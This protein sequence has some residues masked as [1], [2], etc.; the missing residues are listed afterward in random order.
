MQPTGCKNRT[1]KEKRGQ[2]GFTLIE[3]AIAIVV[4]M[5][6]IVAV[7][8]VVP[9]AMQTNLNSR[10]DTTATVV[11]QREL[12]QMLNQ[13]LSSNS[14]TDADGRLI[15]LGNSATP[16]VVVGGPVTGAA[17]IDFN[18]NAVAGYNFNY[19]DAN[20][21]TGSSYEVR[22][23]VVTQVNARGIVASKRIII[24]CWQRNPQ[25][26]TLPVNI[27]TTLQKF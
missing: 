15:N 4:L 12:D 21:P 24:G 25:Q 7:V 22:W 13:P 26:P 11:A 20:D 9:V 16:N 19:Q 2:R 17:Q 1:T 8:Q 6:G 10:R 18:A 3:L 27:D 14:F 5:V 23:A